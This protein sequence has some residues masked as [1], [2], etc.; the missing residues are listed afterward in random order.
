MEYNYIYL[1]GA[2]AA[3]SLGDFKRCL[4]LLKHAPLKSKEVVQ[5]YCDAAYSMWQRRTETSNLGMIKEAYA[6]VFEDS[7]PELIPVFEYI[8]LSNIYIF[9]YS[10]SGAL[11]IM[12]LAALRNHQ[13]EIICMLQSWILFRKLKLDREADEYITYVANSITLDDRVVIDNWS[14]VEGSNFYFPYVYLF[15]CAHLIRK[16]Y[17]T[18]DTYMK[19]KILQRYKVLI[20]EAYWIHFD[21]MPESQSIANAWFDNPQTWLEA[22]EYLQEDYILLSEDALWEVY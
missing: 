3:Y 17:N 14:Y 8:R 4:I 18:S 22:G 2:Q 19:E 20:T 11:K 10:F 16:Y 15:C 13:T 21:T 6:K 5:L 12:Q 1:E 9:E 7:D